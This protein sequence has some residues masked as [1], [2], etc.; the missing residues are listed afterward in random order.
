MS[1]IYVTYPKYSKRSV[2]LLLKTCFADHV[3]VGMKEFGGGSCF[4]VFACCNWW[5]NENG[6]SRENDFTMRLRL[7]LQETDSIK[8]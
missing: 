6:R 5:P 8:K 2:E 7:M 3:A 1:I 4:L